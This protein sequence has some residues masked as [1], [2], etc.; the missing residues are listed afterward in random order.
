MSG[1]LQLRFVQSAS[2]HS[3]LPDSELEIAVIGRSNVGKSSLLNA[4]SNRKSLAK[5]SK[6]PGATKL[7]NVFEHEPEG[8]KRWLVD[9]PGYGYAR[10]PKHEQERWARMIENYLVE[11]ETLDMALLL[12]DGAVGPTALDIQTIEWLT[13]IGLPYM[14]VATKHDKVKPS[15]LGARK[16][17]VALKCGVEPADVMWVSAAKGTGIPELRNEVRRLLDAS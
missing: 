3:Q 13:H 7:I 4:L 5:T 11:R 6:T 8:S 16:Q 1:P 12:V 15:K 9:L 17:E 10:A 14:I 2:K